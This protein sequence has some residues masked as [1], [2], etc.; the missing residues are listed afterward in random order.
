[1]IENVAGVAEADAGLSLVVLAVH[2]LH[3]AMALHPW[4]G[5]P[6]IA[7]RYDLLTQ[8][9]VF[10]GPAARCAACRQQCT[11][12]RVRTRASRSG[13]GGGDGDGDDGAPIWGIVAHGGGRCFFLGA[14]GGLG[15]KG[16][17]VESSGILVACLTG[18]VQTQAGIALPRRRATG[19]L[20]TSTQRPKSPG[21]G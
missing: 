9:T 2:M 6:D 17:G 14:A 8:G 19:R 7:L 16:A 1:M 11:I 13:Q 10:L 4:L 21:F 20:Q 12:A 3:L 5:V 15:K 18:G